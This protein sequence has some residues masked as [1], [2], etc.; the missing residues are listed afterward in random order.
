[1]II[2][3]LKN[4]SNELKVIIGNHKQVRTK[5]L[6][7]VLNDL[8]SKI[9]EMENQ[10]NQDMSEPEEVITPNTDPEKE[11]DKLDKILLSLT[12][13]EREELFSKLDTDDLKKE[14]KYLKRKVT[15]YELKFEKQKAEISTIKKALKG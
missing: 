3:G 13:E 14:N 2:Q 11:I 15:M 1:M 9:V 5:K 10:L 6:K 4:V 12:D 8:D 7:A